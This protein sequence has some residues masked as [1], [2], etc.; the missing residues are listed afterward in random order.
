ML[1]DMQEA[2]IEILYTPG[3]NKKIEIILNNM[4]AR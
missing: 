4:D 1:S 2:G 3:I